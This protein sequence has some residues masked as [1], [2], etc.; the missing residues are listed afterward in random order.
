LDNG[1]INPK[2]PI[3]PARGKIPPNCGGTTWAKTLPARAAL[4]PV[5]HPSH[6]S[7]K[8]QQIAG[9]ER[10]AANRFQPGRFSNL[11]LPGGC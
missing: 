11:R 10:I 5:A 7:N 3:P 1:G 6:A 4:R 2:N 9:L 8:T